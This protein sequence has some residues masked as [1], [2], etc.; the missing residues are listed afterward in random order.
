VCILRRVHLLT[1]KYCAFGKV[2]WVWAINS[3]ISLFVIFLALFWW[4]ASNLMVFSQPKYIRQ[5]SS[6][7][8]FRKYF[9]L[10]R[11]GVFAV[12]IGWVEVSQRFV[13]QSK[14]EHKVTM[15]QIA[16]VHWLTASLS[17]FQWGCRHVVLFVVY[18]THTCTPITHNLNFYHPSPPSPL[19]LCVPQSRN[20]GQLLTH[21]GTIGLTGDTTV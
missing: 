1:G 12:A 7:Q 2:G 20:I 3:V 14:Y 9:P 5:W 17:P 4:V 18:L 21:D 8:A 11:S 16:V 10:Q 13:F 6:G 19:A 15:S